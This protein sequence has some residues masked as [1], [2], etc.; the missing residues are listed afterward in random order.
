MGNYLSN[1][2]GQQYYSL[3]F[4]S[5]N[6]KVL[7]KWFWDMLIMGKA[8]RKSIESYFY[9]TNY[10]YAFINIRGQHDKN[11]PYFF[12]SK[13]FGHTPRDMNLY[14]VVDGVFYIE[15]MYPATRKY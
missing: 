5:F 13:I 4:T 8:K 15:K 3:A 1:N 14:D 7:G 9:K 2:F 6:G 11:N 12:N 10:D